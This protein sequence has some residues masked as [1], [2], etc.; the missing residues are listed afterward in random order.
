MNSSRSLYQTMIKQGKD[1]TEAL[2]GVID[3]F[4]RLHCFDRDAYDK[5]IKELEARLD[6]LDRK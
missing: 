5:R 1:K 6:A 2:F 4:T 3:H